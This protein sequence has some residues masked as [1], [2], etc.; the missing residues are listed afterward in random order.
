MF[1]FL[2]QAAVVCIPPVQHQPALCSENGVNRAASHARL[3]IPEGNHAHAFAIAI[4]YPSSLLGACISLQTT[5]VTSC[6]AQGGA[7]NSNYLEGLPCTV[8]ASCSNTGPPLLA[9]CLPGLWSCRHALH[10]VLHAYVHEQS[11]RQ[12]STRRFVEATVPGTVP[13]VTCHLQAPKPSPH[14]TVCLSDERWQGTS[15]VS[16]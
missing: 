10:Q 6:D 8:L 7:T 12:A 3:H 15:P 13:A 5:F 14:R 11:Q 2:S 9:V 1:F 4:G 16:S